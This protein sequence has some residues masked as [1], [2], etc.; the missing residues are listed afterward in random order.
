MVGFAAVFAENRPLSD[1]RRLED[2]AS[3]II[4]LAARGSSRSPGRSLGSRLPP[5]DAVS[6]MSPTT[7]RA[8]DVCCKN[9]TVWKMVACLCF[10]FAT[11]PPALKADR[12]VDLGS[13][14]AWK[15]RGHQRRH[16]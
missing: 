12:A 15:G 3:W 5:L 7:S 2:V 10:R 13:T 8:A 14:E 9:A 16:R 1:V 4:D 11:E 6:A